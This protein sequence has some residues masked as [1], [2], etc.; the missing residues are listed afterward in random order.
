MPG[1]VPANGKPWPSQ[2]STP[3]HSAAFQLSTEK[4][5]K[6]KSYQVTGKGLHPRP[7][8]SLTF[9]LSNLG[10]EPVPLQQLRRGWQG[11]SSFSHNTLKLRPD[12]GYHR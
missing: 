6:M 7:G 9:R 3:E 12:P 10:D 2:L 5:Q 11:L 8:G 1:R 4:E